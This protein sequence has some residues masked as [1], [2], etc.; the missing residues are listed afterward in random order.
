MNENY[1]VKPGEI[2]ETVSHVLDE[3]FDRSAP[4]SS[5][6]PEPETP[7]TSTCTRQ[8]H[9][10]DEILRIEESSQQNRTEI[11][12]TLEIYR[13]TRNFSDSL[14]DI[15]LRLIPPSNN[16]TV[17]SHEPTR[18]P[19]VPPSYSTVIKQ[20]RPRPSL[21]IR[22]DVRSME[23]HHLSPFSRI[24]PPSYAEIQGDWSR[25]MSH[26]SCLFDVFDFLVDL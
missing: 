16:V 24:P 7:T 4:C 6:S 9:N 12:P 2:T 26:T 5:S 23:V 19:A 20:G 15:D 13:T 3:I 17:I 18:M 21:D 8:V 11:K 1:N 22:R 25:E 14:S 10:N